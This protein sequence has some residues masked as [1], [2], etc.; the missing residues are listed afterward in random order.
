MRL[1][2]LKCEGKFVYQ[3]DPCPPSYNNKFNYGAIG[4]TSPSIPRESCKLNLATIN[5][6][7]SLETLKHIDQIM[8][9]K[10]GT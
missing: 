8:H 4:L 7:Q 10:G 5:H 6:S 1:S 9:R 3:N 2:P